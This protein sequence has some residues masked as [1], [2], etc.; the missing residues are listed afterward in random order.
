MRGTGLPS[1]SGA[2]AGSQ[3]PEEEARRLD[4]EAKALEGLEDSSPE[5]KRTRLAALLENRCRRLPLLKAEGKQ[6]AP[7][8]TDR[9][10]EEGRGRRPKKARAGKR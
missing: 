6:E 5:E 7:T 10:A 2:G 3:D 4:K 9:L 1:A 8:W